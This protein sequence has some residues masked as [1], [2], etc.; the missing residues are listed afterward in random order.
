[1][2]YQAP[3]GSPDEIATGKIWPGR[4]IDATPYLT[5]Y[6]YGYHTGA[7]L[8]LNYPVW[9]ADQHSDV[10]AMG[11]GK[12]TYAKLFST[13]YWGN[14]IVIDH[15]TVDGMPLFSRY[16]HVEEIK[17][18]AGQV[19]TK[20]QKIAKV[21]NGEDLFP[22]HLH[23]DISRTNILAE[24]PNHWPA[25]NIQSCRIN[26]VEPREWLLAHVGGGDIIFPV[27]V[28]YVT[29]PLGL[30]VRKDHNPSALQKGV[31]PYSARASVDPNWVIQEGYT[32]GQLN[33]GAFYG[34]WFALGRADLSETFVST[35]PPGT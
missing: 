19:V 17:V 12:V 32:W 33:D 28:V 26:Y 21:G 13:Q 14:I 15:G 8:N 20:D 25:Q 1:M 9:D 4:W 22:Y 16:G 24:Q 6:S 35:N 23:F 29:A 7:D 11:D 10:Y 31:L 34:D 27:R 18:A 3:I 30:R 2:S 5:H